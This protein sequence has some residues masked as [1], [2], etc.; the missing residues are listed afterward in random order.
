VPSGW[1]GAVNG[2]EHGAA[3]AVPNRQVKVAGSEEVNAKVGEWSGV[4]PEGPA[5]VTDGGNESTW[6]SRV[7]GLLSLCFPFLARTANLCAP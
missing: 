3:P 5:M 6:N 1:S 7:A 2:L 4:I